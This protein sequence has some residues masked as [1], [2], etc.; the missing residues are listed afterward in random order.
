MARHRKAVFRPIEKPPEPWDDTPQPLLPGLNV[1][2]TM[3][4]AQVI[5]V[6]RQAGIPCQHTPERRWQN[7]GAHFFDPERVAP[8]RSLLG[9]LNNGLVSLY[10]IF[11]NG[12]LSEVQLTR[13]GRG[14]EVVAPLVGPLRLR[15]GKDGCWTGL[16]GAIVV[17]PSVGDAEKE[18][19][20][21]RL[22]LGR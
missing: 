18:M 6:H 15:Q 4:P 10:Y 12:R 13:V 2:F 11:E 3:T 8:R 16:D 5:A 22:N 19:V 17:C 7:G 1:S 14:R 21:I 9:P 20:S